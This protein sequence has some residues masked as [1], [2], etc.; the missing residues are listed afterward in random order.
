VIFGV[1][2]WLQ[3]L[4]LVFALWFCCF[5]FDA[6]IAAV[7]GGVYLFCFFGPQGKDSYKSFGN[8]LFS[9]T[10][11]TTAAVVVEEEGRRRISGKI[12]GD[13]GVF[14]VEQKH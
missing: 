7:E 13:F 3:I 8:L 4:P 10:E 2:L 12:L 6:A 9:E 5:L 1:Q 11:T 14:F